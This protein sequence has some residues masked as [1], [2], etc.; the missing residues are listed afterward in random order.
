MQLPMVNLDP[1]RHAHGHGQEYEQKHP[2]EV[3]T[4]PNDVR[5]AAIFL[6]FCTSSHPSTHFTQAVSAAL[7]A[8]HLLNQYICVPIVF[9]WNESGSTMS[10]WNNEFP[11]RV[12]LR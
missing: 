4:E 10:Y 12:F 1:A 9:F 2:M 11:R 5:D 8:S 7:A 3:E 6:D